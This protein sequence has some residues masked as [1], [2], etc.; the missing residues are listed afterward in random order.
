MRVT[1]THATGAKKLNVWSEICV[2]HCCVSQDCLLV[3]V[4]HSV[5]LV[6]RLSTFRTWQ[7]SC[8]VGKIY[9]STSP[10]IPKDKHSRSNFRSLGRMYGK[11]I[12]FNLKGKW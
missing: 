11:F 10:D 7:Y 1:D 12:H 5:L 3:V 9:Q 2:S 8:N 4:C 6:Q